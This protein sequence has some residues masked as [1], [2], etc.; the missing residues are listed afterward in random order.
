MYA[1]V[2]ACTCTSTVVACLLVHQKTFHMI[3]PHY[4]DEVNFIV[5]PE[6]KPIV[7][8]KQS[9]K[10]PLIS[11]PTCWQ[12]NPLR[13]HLKAYYYYHLISMF[14]VQCMF[15][16]TR[17][18]KRDFL[19]WLIVFKPQ[20]PS[21]NSRN[22]SPFIYLFI[23]LPAFL[24]TG[25]PRGNDCARTG[26]TFHARCHPYPIP[27]LVKVGHTTRVYNPYSF[28]IVMWVLLHPTRSN[29][30]K[31]FEMGP[32][33]FHPYPRRL[34]SLTI[35]R[36]HFKGSTFSSVECWINWSGRGLNPRPPARQNGALHKEFV[37][38]IQ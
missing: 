22:W 11:D 10:A 12:A 4:R 24:D 30:W 16:A 21:A 34:G 6:F 3:D 29:Q 33:V 15:H 18:L 37:K 25:L 35:C 1:H 2:H 23:Y 13:E 36:C 9:P 7:N 14:T 27:Q 31:C 5:P 20:Y 38:R 17:T 28:R 19:S 26:L 32:T 8:W